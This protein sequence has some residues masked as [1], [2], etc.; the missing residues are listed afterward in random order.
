MNLGNKKK[1]MVENYNELY[2]FYK[3]CKSNSLAT[4]G[5]G[6]I[7]IISYVLNKKNI[8]F[9]TIYNFVII[10]L[11]NILYI[12]QFDILNQIKGIEEDKIN[13][14]DRPLASG[15]LNK[16]QAI[17]RY[18][19]VS[20]LYL[21][22]SYKKQVFLESFIWFIVTI[23]Y[24]IIELDKHWFFK[25]LLMA[26]AIYTLISADFYILYNINIT[27][28]S[29]ALKKTIILTIVG[30]ITICVQEFRDI[31]GD[32]EIGR[33]TFPIRFGVNKARFWCNIF[34]NIGMVIIN[35]NCLKNK[36]FFYLFL[37]TI[38]LLTIS[39]RIITKKD[40][41][42]DQI[43]YNIWCIWYCINYLFIK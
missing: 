17:I 16:Y 42:N 18:I 32:L 25:S 10:I 29:D 3:F 22:L 20:F 24:N 37:N 12:Y 39:I 33:K 30:P 27:T 9:T 19:I 40:K 26:P 14:P 4:I 15:L 11:Y 31:D 28:K 43:T 2:I 8:D 41:Y 7:M 13:K 21:F 35:Y 36:E 23:L 38:L 5:P 1:Q 6:V 34:T